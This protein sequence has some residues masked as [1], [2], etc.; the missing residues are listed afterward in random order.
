MDYLTL[1]VIADPLNYSRLRLLPTVFSP[2][3]LIMSDMF[4]VFSCFHDI[5]DKT[6]SLV[7]AFG[8]YLSLSF[9]FQFLFIYRKVYGITDV[10][11]KVDP[12]RNWNSGPS[13]DCVYVN[14]DT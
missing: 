4:N 8:A 5:Y 14:A 10:Y 11:V 1:C 9:Q 2:S 3:S 12:H 6:Y 7:A 13:T